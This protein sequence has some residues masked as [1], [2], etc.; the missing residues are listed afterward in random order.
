MSTV[1]DSPLERVRRHLVGLKMPRALETLAST[2]ARIE[3]A[4]MLMLEAIE[5]RL[6]EEFTTR[7]TRRTSAS[8]DRAADH[9]QDAGQ[10]RLQLP[11][12]ARPQSRAGAGSARLPRAVATRPFSGA[13]GNWAKAIWPW[14]S[15]WRRRRLARACTSPRSLTLRGGP[16][17]RTRPQRPAGAL[18][19]AGIACWW[20]T[21]SGLSA[22]RHQR[23]QSV[24][25]AGECVLRERC[26]MILTS[27]R[28]FTGAGRHLRRCGRRHGMP[29]PPAASR[30]RNRHRGQFVPS[31]RARRPGA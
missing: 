24:L 8:Q 2:L 11:A 30:R 5:A 19:V 7:Q 12:F 22:G 27:N 20:S 4:E 15:A 29:R 16:E 18:P 26:A 21:R 10:L 28:W 9:H 25:P 31:A 1:A 14:P 3:Q 6:G 17:G 23:R 13:A